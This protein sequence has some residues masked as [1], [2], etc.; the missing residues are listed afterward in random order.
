MSLNTFCRFFF[1][2]RLHFIVHFETFV[3]ITYLFDCDKI[4]TN[5]NIKIFFSNFDYVLTC[6]NS[7]DEFKFL[8]R[9]STSNSFKNLDKETSILANSVTNRE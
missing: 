5:S 4:K 2:K 3:S 1:Y 9:K 6:N 7:C 8:L